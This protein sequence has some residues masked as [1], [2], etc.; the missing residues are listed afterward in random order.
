MTHSTAKDIRKDL[1]AAIDERVRTLTHFV[2]EG[3]EDARE[4]AIRAAG[5]LAAAATKLSNKVRAESREIASQAL[6]EI[7]ARPRLSAGLVVA[8]VAALAGLVVFVVARREP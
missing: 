5:A 3:A 2:E 7:K 4:H 8:A 1:E 6:D